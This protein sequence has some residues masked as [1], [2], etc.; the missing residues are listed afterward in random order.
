MKNIVI[1]FIAAM[2]LQLGFGNA[3]PICKE[4]TQSEGNYT[5]LNSSKA[6]WDVAWT[7]Q[8]PPERAPM[9]CF[10][11]EG[12][13][14]VSGWDPY[15]PDNEMG[16]IWR[17]TLNGTTLEPDGY[18][19]VSGLIGI[20]NFYGFTT[21]G[22][23]IYGVNWNNYIY[24]IDPQ[25]WTIEKTIFASVP[26]MS[27]I[28][29]D[30]ST[31]GFWLGPYSSNRA[32]HGVINASTGEIEL[33]GNNLFPSADSDQVGLAY[34]DVTEG[35]PYLLTSNGTSS[36]FNKATIGRWH[37]ATKVFE[38]DIYDLANMP[39]GV[40]EQ[41]IIGSIETY[42]RGGKLYLLGINQRTETI[43][44]L[45]LAIESELGAPAAVSN[46][47]LTPEEEGGLSAEL[48]WTN[49]SL[50]YD[51]ETLIELTSINI[52]QNDEVTPIHTISNPVI[53]AAGT[54][55]AIVTVPGMYKFCVAGENS[56][57]ESVKECL[58]AWIGEDVPA[59]PEN[60]LLEKDGMVATLSWT[61]PTE[62]VHGAYFSGTGVI[63]DVYRLPANTL[64]SGNQA[65]LTFTETI[66]QG[67]SYSYK[68]VAKNASGTGESGISNIIV[69][70]LSI[71]TFPFT[72]GFEGGIMPNCWGEEMVIGIEGW[73][74]IDAPYGL[75]QE[76]HSGIWKAY[77]RPFGEAENVAKLIMPALDLTGLESPELRFWHAQE[78]YGPSSHEILR[79]YYKTSFYGEWTLLEEYTTIISNWTKRTIALPSASSEYYIAF[80][81]TLGFGWGIHLDD[82]FVGE[83]LGVNETEITNFNIY[84]NPVNDLLKIVHTG[85]GRK[86][87][88]RTRVE[89][90]NA[91]GAIVISFEMNETET[92]LNVSTLSSGLYLIRF[93]DLDRN[94][95]S[96]QR[97]IKQ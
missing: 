14:Y 8:L 58:S 32:Q 11:W 71:N 68:V 83:K 26:Y 69:F 64:V 70:C 55:T 85:A 13:I 66:T 7:Y 49:P 30:K 93:S 81:G 90:Y 34:D 56:A 63:Y 27:G 15:A 60:I 25:T 18:V 77:Y 6:P 44:A 65:G 28:A 22:T 12:K 33:T 84:P 31:G 48:N 21:D 41:N 87:S 5:F 62:G 96:T 61:A 23:H 91:T 74:V 88:T 17:Y 35:G 82:V 20:D 1:I 97:F 92:E 46:L 78:V 38:S 54:Y 79:V 95:S 3:Q 72:E 43:F 40:Q 67:G 36:S 80:E 76:A 29:Y 51:G 45:E 89:I 86:F 52:Y 37:I 9:G 4:S 16:K 50:T 2:F 10:Y 19:V 39:G 75:P 57:G 94:N 59:A 53:G 24:K 73:M 47:T 42:I